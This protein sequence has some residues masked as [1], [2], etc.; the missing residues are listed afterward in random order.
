MRVKGALNLVMLSVVLAGCGG[1]GDLLLPGAG[2][3]AAVSLLQGDQ[4]NGR[5]GQP[6]PQPLVAEVTDGT[7]RPVEGATVVFVLT[8]AAPGAAV[9][10]DTATTDADGTVTANVVLGTRPGTQAGEVH[11]LGGS[12]ATTARVNFTL[13]AVSENANGIQAVSGQDQTG[14]VGTALAS[15][16]VVA[17]ADA[18]GNPIEGVAVAWTP[19]GGGSAS[20]ATTTTGADGQT[21][22]VRTLGPTAGTQRTLATV[23]GLAGSPVTFV[24][25]ATAGSASGVSIV[26][27]DGQ[28][29]PVSTE[30]P[31]ALVVEVRDGQ[32]NP[33]PGV[34]VTWVIGTG[35]GSVTPPTSST[36]QS[37][38]ATAAWTLGAIPGTNTVSAVV[39]GIGVAA[40]TATATAGAPARLTVLTQ[41]SATAV[42]GVA[43]A[44]QP[45]VQLLDAQ[46]NQS[47][48]SGVGVRVTIATGG[49]TLSGTTTRTTDGT[50]RATF[51]DLAIAGTPGPRTLRFAATG[52]ASVSSTPIALGAAPTTTTIT[53]HTPDPSRAGGNVTVAFT[54]ATAAGTPTGT[55]QVRD[56]SDTCS[57]TLTGGKGSCTLVLNTVGTRT[58]TAD[59]AG[60]GGFGPSSGT[61][62]HT[63]EAPPAPVLV[64]AVQP[65]STATLG[66]PFSTQPVIQ[67]RSGDGA[68]L[69]ISGVAVTV[70]IA[71]GSPT[72]SGTTTIAT[73]G[74]GRA[75]FTNL[76]ITGDA[77]SRTLQ[78]T[79]SG[80]TAVISNPIDVRPAPPGPPDPGQSSVTAAPTTVAPGETSTITVT[81]RD[82]AGTPLA[83]STVHLTATG[84]GNTVPADQ[85]TLSDGT[86][87]FGFSSTVAEVKTISATAA[88]VS[89]GSVDVTVQ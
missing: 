15:P 50:G 51:T 11:A 19:D 71:T 20:A 76:S 64:V 32:S 45:V 43:L 54:V 5:V 26:S 58:L 10:P 25:T 46:G 17:V 24:H 1:G 41:P 62:A 8:D 74:Q 84:T 22:V 53:A 82:A 3:P 78:F 42:S 86:A 40:F 75:A 68:D 9:D 13:T 65:S 52:F 7:G 48:Q 18:F 73:D 31:Q 29:G 28:T 35:A 80:Y 34:P 85:L 81:V 63:V 77:G 36:D 89:I 44:Q 37:G 4:Q 66:A 49:G 87:T 67:L 56:G 83:G 16:L 60:A 14:P 27:G 6:L 79:A 70:T 30:L 33:V 69:A 2:E 21:S 59:Y 23:S 57:G 39:S 38:R 12:G 88:G 55:V 72:L 47:Q 61:I